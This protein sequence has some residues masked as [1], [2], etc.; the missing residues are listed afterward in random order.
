MRSDDERVEM[1]SEDTHNRFCPHLS[2][3]SLHCISKTQ[4]THCCLQQQRLWMMSAQNLFPLSK[5]GFLSFS[6][7]PICAVVM[8]HE[9]FSYYDI[10]NYEQLDYLLLSSPHSLLL[11]LFLTPSSTTCLGEYATLKWVSIVQCIFIEELRREDNFK[12]GWFCWVVRLHANLY[13]QFIGLFFVII[14]KLCA[15]LGCCLCLRSYLAWVDLQHEI[16]PD[17]EQT[18][19]NNHINPYW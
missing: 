15:T 12:H 6:T 16:S 17:L 5:T 18:L 7:T 19:Q 13:F 14:L 2:Y 10:S 3:D 9:H 1:M 11:A 4:W 8:H